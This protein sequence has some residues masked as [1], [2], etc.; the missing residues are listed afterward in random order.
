MDDKQL[1]DAID[2]PAA[3]HQGKRQT[4]GPAAQPPN[5]ELPENLVSDAEVDG[6]AKLKHRGPGKNKVQNSKIG[7]DLTMIN[8]PD[9]A[10]RI[11]IPGVGAAQGAIAVICITVVAVAFAIYWVV[12]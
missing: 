6:S 10:N 7:G 2:G 5:S 12:S 9:G 1:T 8:G 4:D 3:R 11:R